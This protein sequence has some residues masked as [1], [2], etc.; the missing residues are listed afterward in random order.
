MWTMLGRRRVE[1]LAFESFGKDW[2][3][4]VVKQLKLPAEVL[5]APYGELPDLTRVRK[6]ATWSLPGTA[7]PR[8]CACPTPT[9]SPPTVRG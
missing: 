6:D 7:R 5:D 9:S 2:V 3:T 1:L 4:D 8:A